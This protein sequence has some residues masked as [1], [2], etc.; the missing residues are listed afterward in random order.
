M[1]SF[2]IRSATAALFAA[3]LAPA[4]FAQSASRAEP[5]NDPYAASGRAPVCSQIELN[6]G[7]TGDEC[8][9]LTLSE[10]GKLKGD[11]DNTN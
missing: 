1:Q 4:A 2:L 3:A 5:S 10:L 6:V 7:L 11:R 9:T 8:G